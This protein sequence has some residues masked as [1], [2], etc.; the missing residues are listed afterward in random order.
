[1]KQKTHKGASKRVKMTKKGKSNSKM[2]KGA[3]NNSHLKRK[4]TASNKHR[5]K[6]MSEVSKGFAKRIRRLINQ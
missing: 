1:M 5:K 4:K 2:L 6:L 3:V